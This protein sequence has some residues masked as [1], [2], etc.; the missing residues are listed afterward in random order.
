MKTGW[1]IKDGNPKYKLG[2]TCTKYS[3]KT[4]KSKIGV[5]DGQ[6]TKYNELG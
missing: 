4:G 6:C 2:S 1:M 5:V 3:T